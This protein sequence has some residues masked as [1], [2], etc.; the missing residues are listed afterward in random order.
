MP[1]MADKLRR[2]QSLTM[3]E[4]VERDRARAAMA[5]HIQPQPAPAPATCPAPAHDPALLA[6]LQR[7][8]KLTEKMERRQRFSWKRVAALFI[9]ITIIAMLLV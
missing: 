3:P 6:E 2:V 8:R 4:D 7:L 9:I 5:P 1:S